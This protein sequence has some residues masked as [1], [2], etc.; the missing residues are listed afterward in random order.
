MV[1]ETTTSQQEFS[2]WVLKRGKSNRKNR[3]GWKP[4]YCQR[5]GEVLLYSQSRSPLKPKYLGTSGDTHMPAEWHAQSQAALL[6]EPRASPIYVQAL[7]LLLEGNL[8]LNLYMVRCSML[9]IWNTSIL[10][11]WAPFPTSI[12]WGSIVS[13]IQLLMDT[14]SSLFCRSL[15]LGYRKRGAGM[16]RKINR[17]IRLKPPEDLCQ[18]WTPNTCGAL[19]FWNSF[20]YIWS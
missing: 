7:V 12:Y 10:Y 5:E 19:P 20:M 16:K 3:S 18:K 15:D 11:G 4:C 6:A 2:L 8:P 13:E 17:G 1:W 14:G 9:Q